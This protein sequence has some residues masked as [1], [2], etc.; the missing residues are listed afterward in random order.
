MPITSAPPL[1][2]YSFMNATKALLAAK[3]VAFDEPHGVRGHNMRGTW[4][5]MALSNEGIRV[6]QRGIVPALA[7]SFGECETTTI[8][9]LEELLFNLP[10]I[11]RTY[12]LT[13]KSQQNLFIP[14][15]DCRFLFDAA[16]SA[17]Y[18]ATNLSRDF[19]GRKFFRRLPATLIPD[20]AIGDDRAIRAT[21]AAPL[22]IATPSNPA[23]I[24]ALIS[25]QRAFRPD[26]N[27]ISGAQTL[28]YVKAVARGPSRLRR[29]PLTPTLRAMRRLSEICRDRPIQLASFLAGQKSWLLTEFNRQVHKN[30]GR[31]C[32]GPCNS[33]LRRPVGQF[34]SSHLG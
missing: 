7:Q 18:F 29:S 6:L 2:Y 15:T 10:W 5:K 21:A 27:Y 33:S 4:R 31:R 13:Y 14:L 24:A 32:A 30:S 34:R 26:L 28:W 1:L 9:S 16:T 23:D 3:G 20:A 22:T 19:S 17:A 11:H 12:R 25:L 8:H